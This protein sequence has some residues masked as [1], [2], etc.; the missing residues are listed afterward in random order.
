MLIWPLNVAVRARKEPEIPGTLANQWS[1]KMHIGDVRPVYAD[2]C[3][4]HL[5]AKSNNI[6]PNDYTHN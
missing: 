6:F 1:A 4:L 3:K 5:N 2:S